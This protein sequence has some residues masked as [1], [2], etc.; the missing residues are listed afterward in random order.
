[1]MFKIF[2][3][4]FLVRRR[5]YKIRPFEVVHGKRMKVVHYGLTTIAWSL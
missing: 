4:C 1:M 3:T 5:K 2:G